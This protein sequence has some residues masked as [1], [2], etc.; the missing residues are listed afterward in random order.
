MLLVSNRKTL[1]EG[2][3]TLSLKWAG[4]RCPIARSGRV[5]HH[6]LSKRIGTSGL[7]LQLIGNWRLLLLLLLR[8]RG[9]SILRT[10]SL[11]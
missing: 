11:L 5:H 9:I 10:W 2:I 1:R 8:E 7:W 4:W 3:C 6:G